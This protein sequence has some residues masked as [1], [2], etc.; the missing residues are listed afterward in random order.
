M[1]IT[2]KIIADSI[3]PKGIRLTTMQLRYPKF[4]HGEFMTHRMFSRNASSSRAIPVE[5]MIEDVMRDPAMPVF[6]GK[7]QAGMQAR[8][9][10]L[11]GD[12]RAAKHQWLIAREDAV[13]G[14]RRMHEL[15]VH[16]QIV[17]RIIEPWLHIN[18]VVTAT[19][20]A[21]FYALR[22]HPDAQPEIKALADA[23][24]EAQQAST[25]E[26]L[27]PGQWHL[28][29]FDLRK[30]VNLLPTRPE[31]DVTPWSDWFN[32]LAIKVSVA[33]CARVSYLTHDGKQPN[34]EEDLKLHD[35]LVGSTPL[36]ASPAEHQA[37]PDDMHYVEGAWL[38]WR[39]PREHGNLR[40]WRQYRKMLPN[41]NVRDR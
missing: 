10:L 32:T 18:V 9:E 12:I 6:W 8:E 20:W 31:G 30:D 15:G 17:N 24:W 26:R 33:R 37:T 38:D 4:I 25:P 3:S 22:R 7:N 16:K 29:Y 28:P 35:R 34:V 40:G 14:A 41:E 21:N 2:A 27:Q 36:H 13:S 11:P 5:R 19:E 23:M 39:T 1:T